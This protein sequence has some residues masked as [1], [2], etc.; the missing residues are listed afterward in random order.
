[1][2]RSVESKLGG[3]VLVLLFLFLL[4]LPVLNYSCVYCIDRQCLFWL[5]VSLFLLLTYVGFCHP[6][7]PFLGVAKFG[8]VLLVMVMAIF[9]GLWLVPYSY[10]RG[11]LRLY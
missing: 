7:A 4:W 8:R 3:L 6:E 10:C 9:K 1:M 11:F 2:L 5:G